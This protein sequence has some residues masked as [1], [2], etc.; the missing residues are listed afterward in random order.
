LRL[1]ALMLAL[2]GLLV[3]VPILITHPQAHFNWSEFA[4]NFL[5]TGSAGIVAERIE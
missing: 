3:W 4:L 5:I 2:F 1:M